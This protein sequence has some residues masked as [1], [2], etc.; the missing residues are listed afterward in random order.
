MVTGHGKTKAYLH[1]LKII[2][3]PTCP[4]G[5]R[6]QT[7]DHL[8]FECELLSKERGILKLSIKDKRL[9]NQQ[10]GPNKEI[11]PRIYKIRL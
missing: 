9:A 7:T 1:R 5:T 8:Q 2:E 10:N 4:C 3:T 11:L 6:D